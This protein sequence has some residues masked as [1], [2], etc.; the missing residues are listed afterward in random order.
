MSLKRWSAKSGKVNLSVEPTRARGIVSSTVV[1][2][3]PLKTNCWV[4]K[5]LECCSEP[6]STKNLDE[7][8]IA[9]VVYKQACKKLMSA[10]KNGISSGATSIHWGSHPDE[11]QI[12]V[13]VGPKISSVRKAAGIVVS[14][15]KFGSLYAKYASYC[16]EIGVKPDKNA[17]DHAATAA[18][19]AINSGIT[20]VATG[21]LNVPKKDPVEHAADVIA[22][23][24]KMVPSSGKG[25]SRNVESKEKPEDYYEVVDA[26]GLDGIV[27]KGY[28]DQHIPGY[29]KL[30]G[31]KLYIPKSS[32]T[33][34]TNAGANSDRIKQY[35]RSLEAFKDELVGALVHT[36]AMHGYVSSKY[37]DVGKNISTS[38]LASA[39]SK[40]LK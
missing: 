36:A 24:L 23:K 15:L 37:L 31:G 2:A 33:K 4:L 40:A 26:P 39:I 25:S 1:I 29:T 35:V 7:S 11:F 32:A 18:N 13:T 21:R 3:F 9:Y 34:A 5:S 12:C 16:R 8:V 22:K 14:C 38:S 17:F 6:L 28:V 30:C 27:V 20:I 19:S 10:D